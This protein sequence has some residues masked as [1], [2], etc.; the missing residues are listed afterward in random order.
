MRVFVSSTT[1]PVRGEI[2]QVKVGLT[3]I[4]DL[5]DRMKVE[6]ERECFFKLS[7]DLLCVASVDGYFKKVNPAF[8]RALQYSAQELCSRPFAEFVHP[9]D[10][11]FTFDELNRLRF[12]EKTIVLENRFRC[13]DGT[14]RHLN[15]VCQAAPKGEDLFY[16]AARDTTEWMEI[17]AD[18]EKLATQL[19]HALTISQA[20]PNTK[21]LD[22]ILHICSGC[23]QIRDERGQWTRMEAYINDHTP[24]RFS[25]GICEDC[26]SRLYPDFFPA[27]MEDGLTMGL[28]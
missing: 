15:W 22:D 20:K 10:R 7:N 3:I 16:A 1:V 14:I 25:H 11:E 27:S 12:G 17:E 9:E 26:M 24:S 13:K 23:R 21:T 4:T 2:G 28:S 5:S 6:R 8:A 19:S 18:R